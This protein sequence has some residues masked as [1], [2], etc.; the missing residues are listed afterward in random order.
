MSIHLFDAAIEKWK[1]IIDGTG[2][3]LQDLDCPFC[4]DVSC[5]CERCLLAIYG[6]DCN[7]GFSAYWNW[8]EHLRN[9]HTGAPRMVHC[10]VCKYKAEQVLEVI[11]RAREVFLNDR[12]SGSTISR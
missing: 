8:N 11:V 10:P 12:R 5:K 3:D 6:Q 1:A 9:N 4:R 7:D 2:E